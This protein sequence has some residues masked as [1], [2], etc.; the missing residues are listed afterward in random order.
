M[1]KV[2]DPRAWICHALRRASYK[3]P[4]R[5]AAK[6][7]SRVERGRYKCDRCGEI[8]RDQEVELDHRNPVVDPERGFVDWNEYISRLF[9]GESGWDV[10]CVPCHKLKTAEEKGRR[11]AAKNILD[12]KEK[13]E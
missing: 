1:K 4:G 6:V 3:W 13:K 8:K 7:R 5:Y 12:N 10:L 2:F 11:A 9:I